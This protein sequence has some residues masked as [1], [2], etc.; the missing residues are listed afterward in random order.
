MNTNKAQEDLQSIRNMMERSVRF[1][2][3]SGW[4]GILVGVYALIAASWAYFLVEYPQMPGGGRVTPVQIENTL[5]HL[6]IMALTLLLLSLGT[7]AYLSYNKAKKRGMPYWN[8]PAKRFLWHISAPLIAGGIILIRLLL[9]EN[10]DLLA[11]MMLL[12][13]GF[14]LI[15]ASHFAPAELKT[16]GLLE[17]ILGLICAFMPEYS[18]LFWAMGFGLLHIIYGAM[19]HYKYDR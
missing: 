13:Y 15:N 8:G 7:A 19:M 18:L 2:S 16:L 10:F 6:I 17:V 9:T 1:I 12:F 14:A 5:L 11:P 3:F 4:S